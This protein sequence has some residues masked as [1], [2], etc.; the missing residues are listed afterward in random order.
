M[1]QVQSSK[2]NPKLK[3]VQAPPKVGPLRRGGLPPFSG[4]ND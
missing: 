1:F 3:G 2:K 4:Q